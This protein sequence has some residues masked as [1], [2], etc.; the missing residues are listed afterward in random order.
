MIKPEQ[1]PI[2]VKMALRL[3][4]YNGE[5]DEAKIAADLIN[6]WPGVEKRAFPALTEQD[7]L[8][9]RAF[10]MLPLKDTADE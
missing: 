9:Q 8:G 4:H 7:V 6:A 1:I 2:Q 3:A 5:T 10:I